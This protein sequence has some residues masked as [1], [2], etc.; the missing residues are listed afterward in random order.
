MCAV[1]LAQ[2]AEWSLPSPEVRGS[3]AI[4]FID[5]IVPIFFHFP[6]YPHSSCL[7]FLASHFLSDWLSWLGLGNQVGS[8][9]DHL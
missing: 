9:V 5:H 4:K 8:T 6:F 3:N 7:T 2:L 1:V